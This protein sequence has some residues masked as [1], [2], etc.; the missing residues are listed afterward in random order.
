MNAR[1]KYPIWL[2]PNLL[3]LDAPAVAIVWQGLF[4]AVLGVR[5]PPSLYLVLGA[6]VWLVYTADHLLDAARLDPALPAPPRHCFVRDH[7]RIFAALWLA[8]AVALGCWI[9]FVLPQA[10]VVRGL[11]FG[12]LVMLYFFQ[13]ERLRRGKALFVSKEVACGVLFALGSNLAV[14]FYL[15]QGS[16]G[17]FA[18]LKDFVGEG[19]LGAAEAA[20]VPALFFAVLCT[21]NCA[22]IARWEAESDQDPSAT[23]LAGSGLDGSVSAAALILVGLGL[24]MAVFHRASPEALLYLCVAAGSAGLWVLHRREQRLSR[25]ALRLWADLVLLVPLALLPLLG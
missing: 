16:R 17:G 13:V 12:L 23:P 5:L 8:V 6:A 7:W 2:W 9:P 3:N 14:G 24:A 25:S 11:F 10:L 18:S 21:L 1:A 22:A 19:A 20:T 4:A 15:S